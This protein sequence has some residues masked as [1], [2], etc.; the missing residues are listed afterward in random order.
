[1]P[2][3]TGLLDNPAAVAQCNA[4][5][6][7]IFC[8]NFAPAKLL[9]DSGARCAM[10]VSNVCS[11]HKLDLFGVFGFSID[12]CSP[13]APAAHFFS[14]LL[15]LGRVE[16]IIREDWCLLWRLHLQS[17]SVQVDGSGVPPPPSLP[18]LL[19]GTAK[20]ACMPGSVVKHQP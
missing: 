12:N 15:L 17:D 8:A 1:M 10:E 20:L 14:L 2:A 11:A 18:A 16:D 5:A 19:R 7:Q 4:Q 9:A 6:R 3:V 13:L